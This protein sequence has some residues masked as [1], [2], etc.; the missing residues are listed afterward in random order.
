MIDIT[1]RKLENFLEYQLLK[2]RDLIH[3]CYLRK[4][5]LSEPE[6]M[7]LDDHHL[8]LICLLKV[9]TFI[10]VPIYVY[11]YLAYLKSFDVFQIYCANF[12]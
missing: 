2:V 3:S 7:F 8:V 11:L 1:V 4:K 10:I 12:K 5:N 6:S 9:K